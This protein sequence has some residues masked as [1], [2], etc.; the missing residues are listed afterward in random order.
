MD[1]Y[2]RIIV[3]LIFSIHEYAYLETELVVVCW[4]MVYKPSSFS[5]I[6]PFT[7]LSIYYESS[8]EFY[9]LAYTTVLLS[10]LYF[11]TIYFSL[12]GLQ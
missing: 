12:L 10:I 9:R 7:L 8:L 6:Q 3:F 2:D 5:I 4:K 11:L 1:V